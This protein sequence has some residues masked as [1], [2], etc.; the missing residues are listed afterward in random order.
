[1][2]QL[3]SAGAVLVCESEYLCWK[4]FKRKNIFFFTCQLAILSGAT[5][6]N[7]VAPNVPRL[8]MF[9]TILILA[10]V[11]GVSYPLML[12]LRLRIIYKFNLIFIFI[13]IFQ[14]ILWTGLKYFWLNWMLTRN[15]WRRKNFQILIT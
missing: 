3:I 12:L 6:I 10:F 7:S 8:P 9:I 13:P 11:L 15:N 4:L 14:S 1:M 5:A 2:D